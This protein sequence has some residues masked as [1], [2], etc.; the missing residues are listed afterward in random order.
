M[1]SCCE[2]QDNSGLPQ[3][4]DFIPRLAGDT[5]QGII[6]TIEVNE[7]PVDLTGAQVDMAF[8]K[9]LNSKIILLLSTLTNDIVVEDNTISI[10]PRILD[11]D[12]ATYIYDLQV[13]FPD[14]SVKTYLKGNF[15][16]LRD[17]T[18]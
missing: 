16:V 1:S 12:P 3:T 17:I 10:V 15:K 18:P 8:K 11:L 2:D 9:G 13:T 4:Y 6:F 5:W 14:S 7:E